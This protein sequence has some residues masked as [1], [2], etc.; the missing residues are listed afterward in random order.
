MNVF[1]AYSTAGCS[2]EWRTGSTVNNHYTPEYYSFELT[3]LEEAPEC[4]ILEFQQDRI[5]DIC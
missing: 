1:V 3:R 4:W 5:F 2:T